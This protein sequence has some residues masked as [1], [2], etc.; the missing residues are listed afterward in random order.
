MTLDEAII[1][2]E[3]TANKQRNYSKV[4]E[5]VYGKNT[6][7]YKECYESGVEHQQLANWLKELKEFRRKEQRSYC[8]FI[9]ENINE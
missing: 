6:P 5:Q 2:A 1:H 3:K 8:L 9:G 4:I 7:E